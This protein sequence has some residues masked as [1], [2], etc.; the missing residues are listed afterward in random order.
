[1][2]GY[3]KIIHNCKFSKF[4]KKAYNH[5]IVCNITCKSSTIIW[6]FKEKIR[7]Q[8]AALIFLEEKTRKLEHLPRM[9]ILCNID[10]TEGPVQRNSENMQHIYR[11]TSRPKCGFSKIAK[12][13]YWNHTSAWVFSCKFAAYFQNNFLKNASGRLLLIE[14]FCN[15][16]D[17]TL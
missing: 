13:L 16:F 6:S 12:Q 4:P 8:R 17:I 9:H 7:S 10:R 5:K 3:L 15:A 11:R 2:K 14:V 1:M